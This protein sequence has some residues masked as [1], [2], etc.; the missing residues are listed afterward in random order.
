MDK[1]SNNNQKNYRREEIGYGRH[2][3]MKGQFQKDIDRNKR[4]LG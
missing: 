1:R 2:N 4:N 3:N